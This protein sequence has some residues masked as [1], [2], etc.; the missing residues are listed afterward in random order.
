V[1]Q[2]IADIVAECEKA[3]GKG[4]LVPASQLKPREYRSSGSIALDIALGGGW[5]KSTIIDVIGKQSAGKTLLFEMAAVEAQ[6]TE[7]KPSVLFDFEGTH[8]PKRF[9]AL[10]GDPAG[11]LLVRAENFSVEVGPMFLEWAADMLKLQLRAVTF[12]CIGMDSTAAM[13]SKAEFD[14]KES[15][16]EEAS[17]MA[18]TARGMASVL[19]QLVGTG[20][21]A[22]S[23]ASLFFMSQMRDNI[24]GRTFKGQPPADKRTGGR[25]LPFFAASQVE[26][27]R[28]DTF[29]ADVENDNGYVEKDTEVGH[30]TKVRVRKNK[31]NAKQGRVCSFKLY[32]EGSVVGLDRYDE[33][34]Q[35]AILTQVVVKSGSWMTFPEGFIVN[36]LTRMQGGKDKLRDLLEGD[37]GFF[38]ALSGLTRQALDLQMSATAMVPEVLLGEDDGFR[39]QDDDYR[40]PDEELMDRYDALEREATN[41]ESATGE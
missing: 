22:R 24:G 36:G 17:T 14:I 9:K 13:V 20:L 2:S 39:P 32:S 6:R 35:L 30:E 33:L 1:Q 11:L 31:N 23:D 21:V 5:G 29:K 40:D 19:R 10:G 16:G 28:G 25:A 18:Y 7:N 26:V 34:A 37:P 4:V 12:A 27:I 38:G 3:F 8:D 15:K 41:A